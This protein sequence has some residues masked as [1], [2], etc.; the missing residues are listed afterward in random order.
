[1]VEGGD[2]T[3]AATPGRLLTRQKASAEAASCWQSCPPAAACTCVR[4]LLGSLS[5]KI[6]SGLAT[7][8][9]GHH[10][11]H[12]LAGLHVAQLPEGEEAAS[13]LLRIWLIHL[14]LLEAA[15][16]L[17]IRHHQEAEGPRLHPCGP[18]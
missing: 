2:C 3:A 13:L 4:T 12:Q 15:G 11:V 16:R 7:W 8:Q 1:M 9:K 5:K 18:P 14:S 6:P 17:Q 10:A